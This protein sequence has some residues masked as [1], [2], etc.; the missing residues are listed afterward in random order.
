[1]AVS[2]SILLICPPSFNRNIRLG[3]NLGIRYIASFLNQNNYSV[4]ILECDLS[5]VGIEE[6]SRKMQAYDIV[7]FSLNYYD[8]Y[9]SV[10]KMLALLNTTTLK[11]EWIILGGYY[12][13]FQSEFILNDCPQVDIIVLGE[14]EK[15]LLELVKHEFHN[16]EGIPNIVFRDPT[17]GQIR[18]SQKAYSS[19]NIDSYPFPLRDSNSYYLGQ[20]HFA[21]VSSRG[22]YGNC[23]FCSVSSFSRIGGFQ[24]RWRLRSPENVIDEIYHIQNKYNVSAIS[25]LDG[26]FIG[27][28][29]YSR[30][31]AFMFCEL[32]GKNNIQISFSIEC[33]ADAIEPQLLSRLKD[34][35]L[36]NVFVGLES[37]LD[38]ALNYFKKNTTVLQNEKA[39]A[40]LRELNIDATYGFIF[41]YPEMTF[42]DY[43]PNLE[44]LHRN[45]IITS[46]LLSSKLTIYYGTAYHRRVLS[47]VKIIDDGFK[48][49][50]GFNDQR[51]EELHANLIAVRNIVSPIESTISKLAFKVQVE[52]RE[53]DSQHVLQTTN[54]ARELISSQ[55]YLLAKELF[56]NLRN[57][58]KF[59]TIDVESKTRVIRDS[60]E[61]ILSV[62]D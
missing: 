19:I 43:L 4:E 58:R 20:P 17:D 15:A 41:F 8:Q 25:F 49:D 27:S 1:M 29:K 23:A 14:G 10:K 60:V 12:A 31:R 44:F 48:I 21:V 16:L 22:C 53:P 56:N 52:D 45:K 50:Y 62:E 40:V 46:K 26:A 6:T 42:E 37:G 33:K 59:N 34:A 30:A 13:T 18:Y 51:L 38:S 35:G 54:M 57:S 39:I 36:K 7:G 11:H 5:G 47:G 32:M 28:D 9:K 55:L 3:E 2:K 24:K 61:N